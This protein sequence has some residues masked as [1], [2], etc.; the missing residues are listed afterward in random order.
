MGDSQPTVFSAPHK[1][2]HVL[3]LLQTHE[4]KQHLIVN[5]IELVVIKTLSV[6]RPN[7]AI[8]ISERVF[9]VITTFRIH[10]KAHIWPTIECRVLPLMTLIAKRD[11][12]ARL[13]PAVRI[14][15]STKNVVSLNTII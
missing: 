13:K 14:H 7:Q 1:F 9:Q 10:W 12:V 4:K 2:A 11:A 6:R 15:R 8:E 3:A 5:V